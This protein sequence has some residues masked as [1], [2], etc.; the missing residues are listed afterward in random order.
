MN[1]RL[2]QARVRVECPECETWYR[3][4]QRVQRAK[5][6]CPNCSAVHEVR[7]DCFVFSKQNESESCPDE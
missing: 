5:H 6:D 2:E 1:H 4:T 3:I 7:V